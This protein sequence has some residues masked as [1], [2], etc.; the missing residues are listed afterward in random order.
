MWGINDCKIP[1]SALIQHKDFL[2]KDFSK[3][4][5]EISKLEHLVLRFWEYENF[6]EKGIAYAIHS[7]ESEHRIFNFSLLSYIEGTKK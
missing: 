7:N 6:R 2:F 4:K 5:G 3:E 1:H